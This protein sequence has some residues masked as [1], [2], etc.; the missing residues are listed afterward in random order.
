MVKLNADHD[1]CCLSLQQKQRLFSHLSTLN[2]ATSGN[3]GEQ[4][5]SQQPASR[6]V[7]QRVF[8][9]PFQSLVAADSMSGNSATHTAASS[10]L[11]GSAGTSS[12]SSSQDSGSEQSSPLPSH[13]AAT[14]GSIGVQSDHSSR[15]SLHQSNAQLSRN[16]R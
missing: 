10:S 3:N 12:A 1:P 2:T 9:G 5:K 16:S 7:L 14:L 13:S 6:N 15:P 8:S 4:S 11:S